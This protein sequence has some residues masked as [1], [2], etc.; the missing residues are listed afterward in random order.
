MKVSLYLL[1]GAAAAAT[2]ATEDTVGGPSSSN[3]SVVL[4]DGYTAVPF[5]MEGAIE[6]G[7]DVMTFTGT[8]TDILAQI[9]SIRPDFTWEDF[10][11]TD[12]ILCS[13]PGQ[14]GGARAVLLQGYDFL[15]AINQPCEVA[16]GPRK[17]AML[18]CRGHP[19]ISSSI[20]MCND[21]TTP[22][23]RSCGEMADYVLDILDYE[24]CIVDD[25]KLLY[26]GQEFDTDNFNI[27]V[28]GGGC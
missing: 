15:K 27:I 2:V 1:L 23:S 25:R 11:P 4:P 24:D 3:V 22:I 7:G 18:F 13:I 5:S 21:N 17:C 26:Q 28:E 10:E 12:K 8:V 14:E 20:W 6:P 16:P 9:Q 19:Y